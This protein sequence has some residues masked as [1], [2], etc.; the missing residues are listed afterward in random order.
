MDLVNKAKKSGLKVVVEGDRTGNVISPFVFV[1][2]PNDSSLASCEIFGPVAQ[3]IPAE[4]DEEAIRFAND[5]EY[6]LSSAILTSDLE[7][8]KN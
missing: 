5:T 7:R 2:V 8:G 4:N 6:G 3:I 1:D